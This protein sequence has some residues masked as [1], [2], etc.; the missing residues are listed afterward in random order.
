M[1][2]KTSV[3]LVL[4]SGG[5]RGLA[6]IG[7]IEWLEENGYEITSISGSSMG[8]LVGGIYA[9]GELETYKLWVTALARSDVVRMLDLSF[10]WSGLLK[11]ERI[12]SKLRD[13]IGD[14]EIQDLPISYTAVATDIERGKE[15]WLSRG[16]LFDAIRAS[17]AVPLVFTPYE[18]NG[19]KLLDGG[20][21]NPL[22]VAPT[23]RD[24]NDITIAVNVDAPPGRRPGAGECQ[25]SADPAPEDGDDD[26]QS[27]RDRINAFIQEL[28]GKFMP[29]KEPDWGFFDVMMLSIETMQST[30]VRMKM[31]PY[32]PDYYLTISRDAARAHEFHRARELIQLGRDTAARH[33]S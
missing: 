11:G 14:R 6:H 21:L 4:G 10:G 20:L 30:I 1:T 32:T 13:L 19:R 7:V 8:A 16:S 26:S 31:A 5:A 2:R 9:A 28:Q 18:I 12:I 24:Q 3:S 33:L 17:I 15:V 23:L 22:P 25:P 29:D 27:Y